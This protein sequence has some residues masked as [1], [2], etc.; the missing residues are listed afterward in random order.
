MS[1]LV[2]FVQVSCVVLIFVLNTCNCFSSVPEKPALQPLRTALTPRGL[3]ENAQEPPRTAEGK[4][5]NLTVGKRRKVRF[6]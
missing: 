5:V 3:L 2:T 1:I 6:S 4:P